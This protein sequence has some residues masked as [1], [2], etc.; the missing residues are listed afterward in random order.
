MAII[1]VEG[2]GSATKMPTVMK[3]TVIVVATAKT[4]NDSV[5]KLAVNMNNVRKSL[6]ELLGS[7]G[8]TS[9]IYTRLICEDGKDINKYTSSQTVTVTVPLNLDVLVNTID[10]MTAQ[11]KYV[12]GGQHYDFL[13]DQSDELALVNEAKR[14]A[15][16]DANQKAQFYAGLMG[17]TDVQ[18]VEISEVSTDF[19]GYSMDR[20]F[21]GASKAKGMSTEELASLKA[22][23]AVNEV[24]KA[25][26]A[27]YIFD[28]H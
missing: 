16:E 13:L 11:H 28:V 4:P 20:G 24:S 23:L 14:K 10:C 3:I 18:L 9:T 27:I 25:T 2:K 5:G 12:L 21:M 19:S 6:S 15:F 8:L 7:N 17:K 1:R 22:S 26:S